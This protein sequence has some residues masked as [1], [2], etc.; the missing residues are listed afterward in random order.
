MTTASLSDIKKELHTLDQETIE[1]LC[2]R[3]AKYK[4][5]NKELLNYLLFEANNEQAYIENVKEELRELFKT[6]PTTNVYLIKKTLR[7][8][9][10]FANKQIKYS[11][12]KQ[13]ELEL[14]IFFCSKMKDARIPRLPGTVLFNLYQQQLKKIED[15][16]TKLPEDLQTDY[17]RELNYILS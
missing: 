16:L 7:K 10:R 8:I 17:E 1:G 13:T 6:I 12:I 14:R 5:E 11:G 2:L 4:K 3:L 9:L 15:A